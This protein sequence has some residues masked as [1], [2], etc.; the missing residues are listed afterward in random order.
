MIEFMLSCSAFTRARV[1]SPLGGLVGLGVVSPFGGATS[2]PPTLRFLLDH[3]MDDK[4]DSSPE[5]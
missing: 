1:I 4:R 5:S 3:V 2:P